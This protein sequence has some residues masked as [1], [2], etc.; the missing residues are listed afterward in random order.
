[1]LRR[2]VPLIASLA[3]AGTGAL[4]AGG[5]TAAPQQAASTT[6]KT[7]ATPF[8]MSASGYSTRVV[9]GNL[10]VMSGKTA[11]QIIGCTNKA[12]LSKTNAEAQLG[13]AGLRVS[14]AK[15]HVY[16]TKRGGTVSS[17]ANNH[18]AK[19]AI[20][21]RTGQGTV[22][23]RGINSHSRAWHNGSGYHASTRTSL[24]SINLN[25]GGIITS[26]P[27]PTRGNPTVVPGIVSI[28]LGQGM[29]HHNGSSASAMLDALRIRVLVTNTTV[30][31]AH[32]RATIHGGVKNAL[33]R[34]SAYGTKVN[35]LNGRVKSGPTPFIVMPCLGTNGDVRKRSIAAVGPVVGVRARAL[36]VSERAAAT[37]TMADAYEKAHVARVALG[38]RGSGLV[39]TGINARAH[40]HRM[41]GRTVTDARGTSVARIEFNGRRL[42][43][44][45]SGVLR[46][47]GLAKIETRLVHRTKGGIQVTAL[48]VTL[49]DG[50]GAVVNVA[51]AKVRITPSGL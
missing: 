21:G 17:N 2:T 38:G 50:R 24:A 45:A 6:T 46:V 3:L 49:L 29:R 19:V 12:G 31:L 10:N 32:S 30:F 34:G 47:Q 9:G 48:R 41:G 36:T 23:L 15:T 37:R 18:I 28:A 27:L 20:A 26:L 42:T 25:V 5:A 8:A 11:F 4:V 40:A 14:A 51:S 43:I 7:V 44:P 1:M 39:I 35:L 16:T 33:F 13:V 22:F